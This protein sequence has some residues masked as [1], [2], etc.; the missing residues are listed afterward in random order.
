MPAVEILKIAV[1]ANTNADELDETTNLN[2]VYVEKTHSNESENQPEVEENNAQKEI[3]HKCG[4]YDFIE[5]GLQQNIKV[6]FRSSKGWCQNEEEKRKPRMKL[7]K[8]SKLISGE[9]WDI[10]P[11]DHGPSPPYLS[12][13][14]YKN[15]F[16]LGHICDWS[17]TLPPCC[18]GHFLWKC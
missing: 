10:V 6:S 16:K 7:G 17:E 5:T 12:C 18:L 15:V 14:A 11:T 4:K 2:D 1:T 13:D 3:S 8:P 9:S